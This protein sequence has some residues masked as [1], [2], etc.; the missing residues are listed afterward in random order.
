MPRSPISAASF[1]GSSYKKKGGRERGKRRGRRRLSEKK[2]TRSSL[3]RG[4]VSWKVSRSCSYPPFRE[5]AQG[6]VRWCGDRGTGEC[7]AAEE[8]EREDE[9]KSSK[10]N[11]DTASLQ[12]A[13]FSVAEG[14]PLLL[15]FS[16]AGPRADRRAAVWTGGRKRRASFSS[17]L[18]VEE[19]RRCCKNS[20]KRERNP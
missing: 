6:R 11:C 18:L 19:S 2:E 9:E 20:E 16:R 13:F 4:K 17:R 7:K 15:L 3:K 5:L 8:R 14:N 1:P 10:K 12:F